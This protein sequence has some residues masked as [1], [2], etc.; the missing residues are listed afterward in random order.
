MS[1][2]SLKLFKHSFDVMGCPCEMQLYCNDKQQFR[3]V[4]QAVLNELDRL[5]CYY[6]NYSQDSFTAAMN[7]TAGSSQGIVVDEETAALLDYS[8]ECFVQSDGLFDIT[9]GTLRKVWKFQA[10]EPKLPTK[11]D[12]ESVMN[13]VG[14]DKVVW[15]KPHLHLPIPG[16]ILDFGGVVKEYAAD[17]AVGICHRHDIHHGL[18][19]LSGD[20]RLLGPH[21]DDKPWCITIANPQKP[22]ETIAVVHLTSGAIVTSGNYERCIE[23]NG[24]RYSHILNPKTGRPVLDAFPS[25][26]VLGNYCLV[27]GSAATIASLKPQD[28]AIDWLNKLGLPYICVDSGG[29][30]HRNC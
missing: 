17:V 18:I 19:N 2:G 7:R 4:Q 26:S 13:A 27:A 14:W 11:T 20:I 28:E 29:E 1:T 15:S 23:V 6:T 10:A 16:M 25:V 5:D 9:A 22:K 30:L 8:H 12:I 3:D 24:I 21:A